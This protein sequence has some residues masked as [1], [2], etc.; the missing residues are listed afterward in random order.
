MLSQDIHTE[1]F[2]EGNQDN[3]FDFETFS[4]LGLTLDYKN[5]QSIRPHM[6]EFFTVAIAQGTLHW[7]PGIIIPNILQWKFGTRYLILRSFLHLD[8]H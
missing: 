4:A 5:D 6:V 1:I 2:S 7:L 3:I 8:M